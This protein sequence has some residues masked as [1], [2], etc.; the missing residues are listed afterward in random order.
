MIR[1]RTVVCFLTAVVCMPIV[2][3]SQSA[4]NI[5][6]LSNEQLAGV[7]LGKGVDLSARKTFKRCLK[8]SKKGNEPLEGYDSEQLSDTF[9]V[10]TKVQL[11]ELFGLDV[12]A[13]VQAAGGF[14]S[15]SA[16]TKIGTLQTSDMTEE[17]S[18][19]VFVVK[20]LWNPYTIDD[21]V[22][23][24]LKDKY[25]EML[26]KPGGIAKF[27]KAC[28]TGFV[29]G[30]QEAAEYY[31]M[32]KRKRTKSLSSSSVN[33]SSGLSYT[34]FG[35]DTSLD[36]DT[37][38]K[39]LSK[40]ESKQLEI[41][42]LTTAGLKPPTTFKAL[43]KQY[44]NFEVSKKNAKTVASFIV[45]Y[46]D[47]VENWPDADVFAAPKEKQ[48]DT[49]AA[50][51]FHL[52]QLSRRANHI[53]SASPKAFAWGKNKTKW[54]SKLKSLAKKWAGQRTKLAKLAQNCLKKN[55]QCD[56]A[57]TW[58]GF[59]YGE[60][61]DWFPKAKT[62]DCDSVRF[63]NQ[64]L[65][66]LPTSPGGFKSSELIRAEM[67]GQSKDHDPGHKLRMVAYMD[68]WTK[69]GDFMYQIT[70][71]LTEMTKNKGV[72]GHFG[73][74][75]H[76]RTQ[77]TI[78]SGSQVLFSLA[79]KNAK[80]NLYRECRFAKGFPKA[81]ITPMFDR[82]NY[83][84]KNNKNSPKTWYG[85]LKKNKQ[86]YQ[87]YVKT[88]TS[89]VHTKSKKNIANKTY[90]VNYMSAVSPSSFKKVSLLTKLTC[91][92][93]RTAAKQNKALYCGNAAIRSFDVKLVNKLDLEANKAYSGIEKQMNKYLK[94]QKPKKWKK[95]K[96][97][98]KKGKKNK[99][100]KMLSS[101]RNRLLVK[102][103]AKRLKARKKRA[104]SG[105]KNTRSKSRKMIR[106]KRKK[107]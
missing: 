64:T 29:Y 45:P 61:T 101:K 93:D 67:S 94:V 26:K 89:T 1:L 104:K 90:Q 46:E 83:N 102:A 79:S 85:F 81:K 82:G 12:A 44:K 95:G 34:G 37:M 15:A 70:G 43:E 65:Y 88:L 24:L 17:N 55:K 78:K 72:F 54:R 53:L 80:D 32:A 68:A 38:E 97:V 63:A 27:K 20:K 66:P 33:T 16:E 11:S 75:V 59:D 49:I 22:D 25:V 28:G 76:G 103:L 21:S 31:G 36:A 19:F 74:E 73:G 47:Y 98:S 58:Q 91:Q 18:I 57:N 77:Y 100:S 5:I 30:R 23:I 60:L 10:E 51:I 48:L 35:V 52:D 4:D 3:H 13:S 96:S 92:N 86:K 9:K 62:L 69:S 8:S 99:K 56:E 7:K 106:K 39:E 105:K 71:D 40:M 6:V 41:S 2:S 14:G 50:A 42:V 107:R 87:G 84:R